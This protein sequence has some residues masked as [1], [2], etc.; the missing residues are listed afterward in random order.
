MKIKRMELPEYDDNDLNSTSPEPDSKR[1]RLRKGTRSCWNCKRRKVKCTFKSA[2]DDVC[3]A[4]HHRGTGC[5]GQERPEE[6]SHA[7]DTRGLLFERV[8]RVEALLEDLVSK[9]G[10]SVIRDGNSAGLDPSGKP[11]SKVISSLGAP[12]SME[13]FVLLVRVLRSWTKT[14]TDYR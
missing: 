10:Q 3:I 5:V 2:T 8:V 13:S 7:E 4:C 11:I 12:R 14:F 9:V 6:E 1:R